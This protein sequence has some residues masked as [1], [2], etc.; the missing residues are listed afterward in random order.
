MEILSFLLNN[1]VIMSAI[2]GDHFSLVGKMEVANHGQF[3]V[4]PSENGDK[5]TAISIFRV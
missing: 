3:G 2:P 1:N 4:G 5:I